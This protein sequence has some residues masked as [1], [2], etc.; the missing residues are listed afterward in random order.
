M[1][2]LGQK[3]TLRRLF[4]H[5]IDAGEGAA[6]WQGRA[7]EL[8]LQDDPEERTAEAVAKDTQ[9]HF[10][11]RERSPSQRSCSCVDRADFYAPSRLYPREFSR[12]PNSKD[13]GDAANDHTSREK[14]RVRHARCRVRRR[15][16]RAVHWRR[17]VA[18]DPGC[19]FLI[20]FWRDGAARTLHCG[21]MR[22]LFRS[23][24]SCCR[25]RASCS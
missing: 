1:S 25:R 23:G 15:R 6:G 11:P 12:G 4:D 16:R 13:H 9:Y 20:K 24:L 18:D 10:R 14:T 17:P 19:S 3:R 5:R 7:R 22:R 21:L 2:A 8:G